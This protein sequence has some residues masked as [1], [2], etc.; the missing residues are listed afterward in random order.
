M[1][2]VTPITKGFEGNDG[3]QDLID[4]LDD[5]DPEQ[6]I[7]IARRTSNAKDHSTTIQFRAPRIYARFTEIFKEKSK[8][9]I[10]AFSD[11]QRSIY[12]LGIKTAKK[13][14]EAD[15][16][17]GDGIDE[18]LTVNER[19]DDIFNRQLA[20]K[21]YNDILKKLK[22]HMRPFIKNRARWNKEV[23][24]FTT[25]IERISDDLLKQDLLKR[26]N[27]RIEQV[28]LELRSELLE[29]ETEEG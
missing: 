9:K 5:A 28:K 6:V 29:L 1:G 2:K 24:D 20:F 15:G 19:L 13:Y 22:D 18:M 11:A 12:L 25:E 16:K 21:E 7:K 23:N 27:N 8:C 14:I 3:G 26:F 4:R 17:I 10:E